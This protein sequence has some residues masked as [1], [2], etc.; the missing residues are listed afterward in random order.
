LAPELI[1]GATIVRGAGAGPYGAGALTG[2]AALEERTSAGFAARLEAGERDFFRTGGVAVAGDSAFN[3][4]LAAS[5]EKDDGWIPTRENR[6]GADAPLWRDAMAGAVRLQS[7]RGQV[8]ISA[9]LSGYGEDR[10]SGLVG[11]ESSA[12]GAA[13]SLTLVSSPADGALGWRLQGW[14]RTSDISNAFV[15]V[16][17]D[18]SATTPASLQYE[19]PALGWGGNGALRFEH[20]E[21]GFDVRAADGETH[22]LFLY[23]AGAFRRS[24]VAGGQ[25]LGIG[26]YAEG[27]RA[28]GDSLVSGGVRLDWWRAFDGVRIEQPSH[29]RA[30]ARGGCRGSRLLGA[31][32]AIGPAPRSGRVVHQERS[33]CR[34]PTPYSERTA[35]PFPRRQ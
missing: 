35:S 31:D 13:A 3:A 25:T 19:T 4:L 33:V 8:L 24:R 7:V 22:E 16:A 21:I 18:R 11:A 14:A 17:P 34:L 10:G 26:A 12:D 30:D 6:G 28:F 15:S 27:W 20:G 9:R 23:Q 2:V 32:G 29:R 5:V 1:S